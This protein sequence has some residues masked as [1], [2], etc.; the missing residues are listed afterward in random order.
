MNDATVDKKASHIIWEAFLSGFVRAGIRI[1]IVIRIVRFR[2][3]SFAFRF[4]G[5][6][7]FAVTGVGLQ[8]KRPFAQFP[9]FQQYHGARRQCPARTS[10]IT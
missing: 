7:L 9:H 2:R 5:Q 10:E 3:G 4:L 1:L 6:F 8:G